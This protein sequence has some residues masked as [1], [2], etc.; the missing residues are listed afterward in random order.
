MTTKQTHENAEQMLKMQMCQWIK[1]ITSTII[2]S[3]S[4]YEQELLNLASYIYVC[5]CACMCEHCSIN[6]QIIAFI[7]YLALITMKTH[8]NLLSS[9]CIWCT[10][11][12]LLS[13][14]YVWCVCVFWIYLTEFPLPNTN[15]LTQKSQKKAIDLEPFNFKLC[16]VVSMGKV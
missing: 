11:H 16:T 10:Q 5:L 9:N 6:L 12:V 4:C 8:T 13:Y 1:T 7:H 15:C 14:I 3:H 2:S